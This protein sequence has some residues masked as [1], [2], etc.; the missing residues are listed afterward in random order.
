MN[1]IIL[2]VLFLLIGTYSKAQGK[3]QLFD[4]EFEE[5]TLN[6]VLNIPEGATPKGIVL[7]VHGS[8]QTNAVAQNWYADVR[9]TM[10]KAGYGTYMWDKMGCGKSGGTFDYNQTVQNSASEVI[11]A[12]NQLKKEEV[13]G[14]S[15]IGLWGISRAGWI[16]PIV[17]NE[18]ENIKFWISVSGVDA[19]ENFPYLFEENLKING[20]PQDSITILSNEL[21][22]GYRITHSGKSFETYMDATQNLRK[23]DFLNRFNNGWV[24]TE[25]GYYDYQ[26]TFVKETLDKETGLQV[27]VAD[28]ESIL[29]KIKCPILALFGER[30]KHVDWKKTKALYEK[31]LNDATPLTVTSFPDCNHNLFACE[32]GGFYEFQDNDMTRKRCDGFLETMERWLN[33]I[34]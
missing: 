19:K 5:V 34:E 16:N 15:D 22:Q 13:P 14:S 26:K 31:A 23:N 25:K 3:Q 32:T 7:I 17:I 29:A 20:V 4:F 1:R 24:I 6:G 9:N 18:Y 30:D 12:I 11:A 21:N 33:A 8:G 10:L 27:Y 2:I 28:F